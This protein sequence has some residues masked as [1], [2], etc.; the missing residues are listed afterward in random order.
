MWG[1]AKLFTF[2]G[3]KPHGPHCLKQIIKLKDKQLA[4]EYFNSVRAGIEKVLVRKDLIE[5]IKE[6]N[7][8]QD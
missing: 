2:F 5:K 1:G 7:L 6:C 8:T 4:Y 3:L